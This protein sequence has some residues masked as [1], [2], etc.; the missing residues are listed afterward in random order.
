V[1]SSLKA[2]RVDSSHK[3]HKVLKCNNSNLNKVNQIHMVINFN[4]ILR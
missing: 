2:L 3:D 4:R 1:D